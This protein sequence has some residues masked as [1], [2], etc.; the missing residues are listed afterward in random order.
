M[1]QITNLY[2]LL[3]LNSSQE[4]VL[5]TYGQRNLKLHHKKDRHVENILMERM[6]K[7]R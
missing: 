1:R 5:Q 6:Q 7:D 4:I 2:Q 3:I